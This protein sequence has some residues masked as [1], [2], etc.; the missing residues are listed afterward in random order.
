MAKLIYS[1]A[2]I[3]DM[4]AVELESKRDE[5]LARA[6][7]LSDFPDLG[8]RN[9]PNS[10]R[11]RYGDSVRKLVVSPFDIVYEHDVDADAVFVL[12]LVRHQ[13]AAF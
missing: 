9:I 4:L 2:F 10:I 5:L 8:S 7:L 11:I 12:G 6:D 3:E 1:D 13:R